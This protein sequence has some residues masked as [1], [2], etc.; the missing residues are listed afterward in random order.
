MSEINIEKHNFTK[1]KNQIKRFSQNAP[2]NFKLSTV[3]TQGG[4]FDLFDHKVT[5]EELNE[6]TSQIQGYLVNMNTQTV[7]VIN[8]FKNVYDALDALDKDYVSAILSSIKATEKVSEKAKKTAEEVEKAQKDL[9][10][11]IKLQADTIKVLK[12][13]KERLDKL[14]HLEH[15][16]DLWKKGEQFDI[17]VSS[18]K[19]ELIEID[20]A[21]QQQKAMINSLESLNKYNH[22]KDIDFIWSDTNTLKDDAKQL[23]SGMERA[24]EAIKLLNQFSKRLESYTHLQDI[25]AIW[26][27]SQVVQQELAEIKKDLD[28]EIRGLKNSLEKQLE[29]ISYL[30]QYSSQLKSYSHL[31]D[32]D[33]MWADNKEL[34]N[35]TKDIQQE[36]VVLQQSSRE[37]E[38]QIV[39]LN[40]FADE[41]KTYKHL[42]DVDTLW[43]A[44]ENHKE[45]IVENKNAINKIEADVATKQQRID[46]L[47]HTAEQLA[48]Y[49]HLKDIDTIWAD[50]QEINNKLPLMQAEQKENEQ[51]IGQLQNIISENQVHY[52]T[53]K[54]ELLKK[55]K[56]AYLLA[57]GSIGISLVQLGMNILGMV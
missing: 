14:M 44:V 39:I 48:A 9:D 22:L 33:D 6:L 49:Q 31:K 27:A 35:A 46:A 20:A 1:A 18:L 26:E 55:I 40:Q 41:M 28:S 36:I 32:I 52:E 57:A 13:H 8:E 56:V 43:D 10:R 24:N 16:D 15:I 23:K 37:R 29:M 53:E 54:Q 25:D 2:T 38:W 4:L 50:S 7:K 17:T 51:K 21:V 34:L 11:T 3:N 30:E 47:E 45:A 5:G 12:Q 42:K 19:N